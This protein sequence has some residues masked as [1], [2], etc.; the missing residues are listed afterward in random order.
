LSFAR[1]LF[2]LDALFFQHHEPRAFAG[3]ACAASRSSAS[4]THIMAVYAAR[5]AMTFAADR[6]VEAVITVRCI[7]FVNQCHFKGVS[8][9]LGLECCEFISTESISTVGANRIREMRLQTRMVV[10]KVLR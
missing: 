5:L 1:R 9:L 7:L 8:V 10:A 3:R 6:N 4:F 2:V